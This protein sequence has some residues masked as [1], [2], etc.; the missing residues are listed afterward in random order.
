MSDSIKDPVDRRGVPARL[1][2]SALNL[3]LPGLGLIRLGDR[4]GALL[5][6]VAP[7]ALAALVTLGFGYLPITGYGVAVA[8]LVLVIALLGAMYIVPT[9]LTWRESRLRE[10]THWWS[11]W[12]ALTLI[13]VVVL[14]IWERVPLLMHHFYKPFYAPSDSMAPTIG[15]GDK[16]V[17]DMRWRGP[18]TRGDIIVFQAADSARVYR[19]A[20]IAGDRIAMR[21]GRPIVNGVAIAQHVERKVMVD[22]LDGAHPITM[23]T[24]RLPG[25]RSSHCLFDIDA[26]PFDD[27]RGVTVPPGHVFVLGDNRHRSA[28]SRVSPEQLGVGMVPTTSI[29]GRA[30][31]IHWS[32]D[33]AKIGSR[34]DR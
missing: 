7:F 16:F 28:D 21:A 6:F 33:R 15:N 14:G 17:V 27:M 19:I 10:P 29:I 22:D 24:E 5:A 13:A 32:S 26:S 18:P 3:I 20:A 8:A 4:R 9:V 1:G 11:R 23:L 34:L 2:L 30:M 31:Y 12:Y 25:E